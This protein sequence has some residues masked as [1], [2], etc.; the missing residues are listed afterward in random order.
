MFENIQ[1]DTINKNYSVDN[2]DNFEYSTI[3]VCVNDC[4]YTFLEYETNFNLYILK[5]YIEV[6]A[7]ILIDE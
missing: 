2:I 5:K 7:K 6:Y 3:N 1:I 4:H